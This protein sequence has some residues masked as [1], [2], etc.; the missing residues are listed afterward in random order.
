MS[1][2]KEDQDSASGSGVPSDFDLSETSN[3]LQDI[4]LAL[5]PPLERTS[6]SDNSGS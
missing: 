2:V 5:W 6:L 1:V 4:S 3:S